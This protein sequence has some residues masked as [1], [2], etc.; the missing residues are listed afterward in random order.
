[1]AFAGEHVDGHDYAI[2]AGRAG[3]VAVPAPGPRRYRPSWSRTPRPRCRRSPPT[4]W[5]GCA[6]G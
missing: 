5:H 3:A 2:Q 1:M 6:T 4:S